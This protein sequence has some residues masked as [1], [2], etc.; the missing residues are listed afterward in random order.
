MCTNR[1]PSNAGL[2]ASATGPVGK[3]H[4]IWEALSAESDN[5]TVSILIQKGRFGTQRILKLISVLS[6]QR[7]CLRCEIVTPRNRAG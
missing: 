5:R 4:R 7:L 3:G 1:E 6:A 2:G